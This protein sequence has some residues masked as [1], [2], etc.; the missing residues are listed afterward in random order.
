M[1]RVIFELSFDPAMIAL[2]ALMVANILLSVIAALAKGTFTFRNLGDFV[3][4]R[5]L[6]LI[7]YF[8]VAPLA[9]FV[10][11][12]AAVAIAMYAG[13]VTLYTTGILAAIKSLTGLKIPNVL[14]DKRP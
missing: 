12:M 14:S 11:D 10:D 3:P 9:G 8:I 6:P 13:L 5:L 7:G 2:V 4:K 1:Q